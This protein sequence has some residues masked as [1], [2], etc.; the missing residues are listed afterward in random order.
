V[1]VDPSSTTKRA[2]VNR[3][4]WQGA[5]C[6]GAV[7]L[8][9]CVTFIAASPLTGDTPPWAYWLAV[10]SAVLCAVAAIKLRSYERFDAADEGA[11]LARVGTRSSKSLLDDLDGVDD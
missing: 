6:A 9:G 1:Q 4:L 2:G 5:F 10:G 3:R 7:V 11:W 8:V